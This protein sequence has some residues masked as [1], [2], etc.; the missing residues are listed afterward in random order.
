VALAHV[1]TAFE[2]GGPHPATVTVGPA[3][4]AAA[5][6]VAQDSPK[7]WDWLIYHPGF[8]GA[9]VLD[10]ARLQT[11]SLKPAILHSTSPP[12]AAGGN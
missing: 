5:Q 1:A 6:Y 11:W 10:L 3:S 8:D 12:A 7:L 4:L 2:A 9:H